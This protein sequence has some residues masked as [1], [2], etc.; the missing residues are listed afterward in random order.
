MWFLSVRLF[1]QIRS[2]FLHIDQYEA[3]METMIDGCCVLLN[4]KFGVKSEAVSRILDG[5]R[6]ARLCIFCA[7]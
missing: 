3:K 4:Q 5:L 1:A 6:L 2:I 7:N